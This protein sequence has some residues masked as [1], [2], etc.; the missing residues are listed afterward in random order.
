MGGLDEELWHNKH[1]Q[2]LAPWHSA[3]TSSHIQEEKEGGRALFF[4]FFL[5]CK[6][7]H[8]VRRRCP[9]FRS[10]WLNMKECAVQKQTYA[11]QFD[12]CQPSMK[13]KK[14]KK[15]INN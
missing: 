2:R 12:A 6:C 9:R 5:V 8:H 3:K 11:F 1:K 14:K 13:K 4:F 7:E 10:L 15:H